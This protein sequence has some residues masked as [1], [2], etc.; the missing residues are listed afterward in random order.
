M[1]LD[2]V[3]ILNYFV[4]FFAVF[5][6][7]F[8]FLLLFTYRKNY[9]EEPEIDENWAPLVSIIIPA[10]NEE[11]SIGGCLTSLLQLDYPKEKLDIVVIDDGS[12]DRTKDEAKKF[13]SSGVRVYTQKN[14]GKGAALNHGIKLAKG[15][16]II[17]MDADSY[18]MPKTLKQL[19]AFF[20]EDE[21]VAAVTPAIKIKPSNNLLVELQRIEY[22]MIIF[23]RK[24]LS[25]IDAVPVTPGPFSMFRASVF[26][27]I[28]GFDE[29]NLVE[30]QEIA[31]RLQKYHFKIKSSIK[32]EVY[33]EPPEN[34]K[35]LLRQRVRWQR[36]GVRNYWNYKHLITPEYGDFGLFF[37]PLNFITLM[38]FFI[39]LGLMLNA[40]LG[41][42]YY[43]RYIIF[44]SVML[45]VNPTAVP[46]FFTGAA[47]IIWLAL[48]LKSFEKEKVGLVPIA[49]YYLFYWYLM[50]GYNL[51]MVYQELKREKTS[52]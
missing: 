24:L 20:K 42:P 22:L 2:L 38:A 41:M 19:L 30:D 35:D 17:T 5:T 43:D 50:L 34:L 27:K 6:V 49:L 9:E 23:S 4:A 11:K 26:K 37:V 1:G 52:W 31:L 3:A 18:V 36:G 13:E 10:H 33:T 14:A 12:T 40:L 8:Y 16:F 32:A 25:F 39:V 44:E 45:G 7:V 28:G 29:H 15:E 46:L 51:L 47:S 48:V 21:E